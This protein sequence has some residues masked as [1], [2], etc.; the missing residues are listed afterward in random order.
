MPWYVI[1]DFNKLL[2]QSEKCGQ[3]QHPNY[4]IQGFCEALENNGLTDLGMEGYDYTW[5]RNKDTPDWV[6]EWLDRAVACQNWLGLLNSAVVRN[7]LTISSNHSAFL[8]DFI[9][10]LVVLNRRFYFESAW[11]MNLIVGTE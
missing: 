2:A 10:E 4:L 3:S 11:I 5:K 9:E 8:L 1:G 6:E 7:I